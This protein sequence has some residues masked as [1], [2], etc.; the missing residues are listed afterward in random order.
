MLD[1]VIIGGGPV[2]VFLACEL[3]LAGVNPVV[4]EKLPEIS[5]ADKAHGL[6]GQIIRLLDHRGLFEP[7]GG[8]GVPTPSP[9]VYFGAMPLVL[10]VLGADN[11]IYNLT[12]NQRDIERRLAERAVELGV[13]LRRGFELRSFTQSDDHVDLVVEDQNGNEEKLSAKYLVGCDGGH[14]LVRKQSGIAFPGTTEDKIVARTAL[15]A[16]TDQIRQIPD[17]SAA[18]VSPAAAAFAEP[19]FIEGYGK[20]DSS[21]HRTERGMILIAFLDAE[22]RFIST[23]EWEDDPEESYPGPGK[24]ITIAEME[25]SVARI[26]GTH[27]G[28][29]LASDGSPEL[30]RR[31]RGRNTRLA[32]R[33]RDRRVFIAGDAAHVHAAAGGPGLNLGFQDA[34]N[35]G[36]KLAAELQGWASPE[37]L[38]SYET[39][40]RALGKRVFMQ[41]LSQTALMAPGSAMTA[42]RELFGEMLTKRDNVKQLADLV[43][44]SDVRYDM[45]DLNPAAQ[46]GWFAPDLELS[47]AD[48][49]FRLAELARDGQALLVDISN[50]LELA[51]VLLPWSGRVVRIAAGAQASL[52][53]ALLI[54]PDGY[55]AWAGTDAAGLENALTR[56]FG[57]PVLSEE[58]SLTS[59]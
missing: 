20:I 4:F 42:F 18:P 39:E 11:P 47:T 6:N 25:A 40:R 1:V 9:L 57:A 54:R 36:W 38:D 48:G 52:S 33:Y 30:L 50:S 29:S 27:V 44:G 37:L 13:E 45:G 15:V 58:L 8:E 21:F 32:E 14:S 43:A 23:L 24:P 7:F 26:L 46:T 12:I 19:I 3:K 5:Q 28:L 49:Q 59:Q 10:D 34:A 51:E 17:T 35:L 56:W 22:H 53:T 55:V 16:A 2:G 41:T 31:I